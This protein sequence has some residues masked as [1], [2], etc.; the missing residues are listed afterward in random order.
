V[1]YITKVRNHEKIV[2]QYMMSAS[3]ADS[4]GTKGMCRIGVDVFA[5]SY[6]RDFVISEVVAS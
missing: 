4:I 1:E 3:D 6:F 2:A 5:F